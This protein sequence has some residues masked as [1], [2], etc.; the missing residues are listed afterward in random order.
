MD[1]DILAYAVFFIAAF[2]GGF[3]DAIAGG[4]GLI[5]VP[6]LLAMGV[7][8]HAALATNK[9]QGSMG[10]L[11]ATLKFAKN[12]MIDFR[13]I[14]IGIVFTLIGSFVGTQVILFLKPDFL[15]YVIP[16]LLGAI[17]IY[18]IFSPKVGENDRAPKL[19]AGTFYPLFG[20]ILGFYDGFFGPG[21]GSFWTFNLVMLLGLNMKKAVANTKALN[22]TSNIVS[23]AAFAISGNMLWFVGLL[24]GFAG[25]LGAFLGSSMVI[26]KEVKFIR[27]VFLCVVAATIAKLVYDLVFK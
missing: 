11:T 18:T 26:K 21:A 24:M 13:S 20:F 3:I 23:F 16:I 15:R 17:F 9:L 14:F 4:G 5:T 25:I 2:A 27:S 6:T 8:P 1:F 10:S 22:F 7:P 12:N 19:K